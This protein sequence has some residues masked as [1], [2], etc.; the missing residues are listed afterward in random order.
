MAA[1]KLHFTLLLYTGD[2]FIEDLQQLQFVAGHN[3]WL[4]TQYQLLLAIKTN[5]TTTLKANKSA[6]SRY[7]LPASLPFLVGHFALILFYLRR[8]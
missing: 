4:L 5:F 8:R 2:R 6:R 1:E 7:K 3:L